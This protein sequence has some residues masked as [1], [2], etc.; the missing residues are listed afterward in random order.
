MHIVQGKVQRLSVKCR[1][2]KCN[3][4]SRIFEGQYKTVY[5]SKPQVKTINAT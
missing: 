5:I 1:C 2:C 4:V 3:G